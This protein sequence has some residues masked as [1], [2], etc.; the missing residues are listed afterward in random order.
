MGTP[1]SLSCR[2]TMGTSGGAF[3][4]VFLT[5]MCDVVEG[6]V[7]VADVTGTLGGEADLALCFLVRVCPGDGE[8]DFLSCQLLALLCARDI[9]CGGVSV[10]SSCSVSSLS[11][12]SPCLETSSELTK[13]H[14]TPSTIAASQQA[15][16]K[17]RQRTATMAEISTRS[18]GNSRQRS[19]ERRT[20]CKRSAVSGRS[21]KGCSTA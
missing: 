16:K 5:G 14:M 9:F 7:S 21:S 4:S 10:G 8:R 18:N 3:S 13:K 2:R 17:A 19:P 20:T 1:S 11:F 6:P 15:P 12:L